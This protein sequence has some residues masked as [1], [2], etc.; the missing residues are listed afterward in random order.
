MSIVRILGYA[1]A[2]V[3][4][5]IIVSY[6]FTY[7]LGALDVSLPSMVERAVAVIVTWLIFWLG[8]WRPMGRRMER[9]N[10]DQTRGG[11]RR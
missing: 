5:L 10:N 4:I 2:F 9:R 1:A 3:V 8:V 11:D 6:A 7:I